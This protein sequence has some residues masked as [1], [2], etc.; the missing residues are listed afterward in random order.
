MVLAPAA[1]LWVSAAAQGTDQADFIA[2]GQRLLQC[3]H[4]RMIDEDADVRA[5][6]LLLIDVPEGLRTRQ[7][8]VAPL[9]IGAPPR[10]PNLSPKADARAPIKPLNYHARH[11]CRL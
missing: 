2:G 4:F 8:P 7:P 10:G 3:S 6:P 5:D 11:C 9:R 1:G